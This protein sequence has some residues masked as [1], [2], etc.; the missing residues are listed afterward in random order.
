MNGFTVIS[1]GTHKRLEGV[2]KYA[3]AGERCEMVS[4]GRGVLA[5][6]KDKRLLFALS[7]GKWGVE[8]EYY[9][10]LM[11][12]RSHPGALEGCVGGVIVDGESEL[13]TKSL[14]REL[15]LAANMAGC[16]F[17]GKPLVEGTGSLYNFKTL[18][19][20]FGTDLMGAY[21]RAAREMAE[22]VSGFQPILHARPKVLTLHASNRATSN[23][24]QLGAAVCSILEKKCDITE[25]SLQNGTVY[26]CRGCSFKT[27]THFSE[28]GNCFYGGVVVQEVY[29]ALL[30]CDALMLLCPNYNDAV[31]ANISACINR[32]TSLL[33]Q[34]TFFDTYLYGVVVSGYSGGDI[35]AGQIL[36]SLCLNK[37]FILPPRF[38]MLETANDPGAAMALPGVED[39]IKI[40]S[41]SILERLVRR[42]ESVV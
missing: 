39:R 24:L 22:R 5:C 30:E 33:I 2:L 3:L 38:C 6:L 41:E 23:T 37:T 35:V 13:Y 7:C 29:P 18:A 26:D 25:I 27:C 9:K 1:M 12:L 17:P 10:T 32:L 42:G 19:S 11:W 36:G 4:A 15:V 34:H 31:G 8:P 14:A 40:Y 20:N 21:R 28:Q 16:L